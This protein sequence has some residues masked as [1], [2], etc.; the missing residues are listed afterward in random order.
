[1]LLLVGSCLFIAGSPENW[2]KI[3]H[4]TSNQAKAVAL[5]MGG[6]SCPDSFGSCIFVVAIK[7]CW[8]QVPTSLF[9]WWHCQLNT[10]LEC[11]FPFYPPTFLTRGVVASVVSVL[12]LFPCSDE[13]SHFRSHLQ[14]SWCVFVLNLF[15]LWGGAD[16]CCS[17]YLWPLPSSSQILPDSNSLR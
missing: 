14:Y 9:T 13:S 11:V 4:V 12:V 17:L 2:H 1:M 5:C 16:R 6:L 7:E 8:L 3:L 15:I 10:Q